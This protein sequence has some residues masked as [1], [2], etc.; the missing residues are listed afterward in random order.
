MNR[1][2]TLAEVA[3]RLDRVIRAVND[4]GPD[5]VVVTGDM[6]EE[7]HERVAVLHDGYDFNKLPVP[8]PTDPLYHV[9]FFGVGLHSGHQPGFVVETD[10]VHDQRLS[11]PV[12]D[13]VARVG[14]P[15]V[16]GFR[17]IATVCIYPQ[18]TWPVL[19]NNPRLLLRKREFVNIGDIH[20]S[21]ESVRGAT[22][23]YRIGKQA[24]LHQVNVL[25]IKGFIFGIVRRMLA[26]ARIAGPPVL[27]FDGRGIKDGG[28]D[29]LPD[30][31]PVRQGR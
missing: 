19:R 16:F 28:T 21:G 2:N 24:L 22:G 6:A 17:M 4:L 30:T 9:R 1:P 27:W 10:G 23:R 8:N 12:S 31:A 20:D 18:D 7:G 11:F 25:L 15:T 3:D 14:G 13:I 29:H 5:A 26:N